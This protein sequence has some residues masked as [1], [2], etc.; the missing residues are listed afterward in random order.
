MATGPDY[1]D[2]INIRNMDTFRSQTEDWSYPD[3]TQ[4]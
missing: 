4:N 1:I 2:D 3:Q